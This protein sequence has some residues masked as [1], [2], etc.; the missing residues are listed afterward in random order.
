[1]CKQKVKRITVVGRFDCRIWIIVREQYST[2]SALRHH[3]ACTS[4]PSTSSSPGTAPSL[5]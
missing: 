1:M 4:S 2:A 3:A 5:G